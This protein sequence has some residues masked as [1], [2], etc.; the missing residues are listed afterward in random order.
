MMNKRAEIAA[1]REGSHH[2][3]FPKG[4][5]RND[6][7]VFSPAPKTKNRRDAARRHLVTFFGQAKKVT[8][9]KK[10]NIFVSILDKSDFP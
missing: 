7:G 5:L 10:K 1:K 6:F 9:A 8:N 3:C 2:V 4:F